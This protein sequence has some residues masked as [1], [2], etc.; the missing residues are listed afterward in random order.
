MKDKKDTSTKSAIITGEYIVSLINSITKDVE[1]RVLLEDNVKGIIRE[2]ETLSS[3]LQEMSHDKRKK[4]L[5]AYSR[6][7]EEIK[8][9]VDVMVRELE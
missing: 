8:N 1:E 7:L 4:L 5:I 3:Y 9:N 6:I 2:A